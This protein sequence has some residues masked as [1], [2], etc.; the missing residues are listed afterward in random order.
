MQIK[1]RL[2]SFA[3]KALGLEGYVG[4]QMAT[5]GRLFSWGNSDIEA[6]RNKIYYAATNLLVGKEIEPTLIVSQM[7]GNAKNLQ[8]YYSKSVNNEQRKLLQVKALKELENHP[9]IELLDEPNDYQTG[10]EFREA[11]WHNYENGDGYII[12]E[13][14]GDDSR[15]KE[16]PIALH[17]ISRSRVTPEGGD[18]RYNNATRYKVQLIGGVTITLTGREVFHMRKWNPDMAD[19]RGF[20][21]IDPAGKTISKNEANQATQGQL[22]VNGGRGTIIS[23]D[24]GYDSKEGQIYGKM[25]AEQVKQIRETVGRDWQG[26]QNQGRVHVVNGKVEVNQF[27]DTPADL[28]LTESE[29]AEWRD[30][31]AVMGIPEP[32]CPGSGA[33]TDNNMEA[34][35]VA[36]VRNNIISKLKKFDMKF[37]QWCKEWYPQRVIIAHDLTDFNELMPD[38]EKLRK[39]YGDAIFVRQDELRRMFNLDDDEENKDILHQYYAPMGLTTLRAISEP[40]EYIEPG[41]EKDY[42]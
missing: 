3:I 4:F 10:L 32:L 21:P 30:V 35:Y 18:G 42:N 24:V 33:K 20:S 9:L 17:A 31:Y 19:V 40:V 5:Y 29:K 23:S 25:S 8:K 15:N 36:L 41:T 7:T 39:V 13:Y 2:Q 38:Y 22:F 12:A 16:Q 37:N 28:Q 34:S 1:Q 6:Y 26:V 27:G 14:P 11:F